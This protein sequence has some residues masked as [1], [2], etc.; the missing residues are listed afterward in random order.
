MIGKTLLTFALCVLAGTSSLAAGNS[1]LSHDGRQ[2]FVA[3]SSNAPHRTNLF[4]PGGGRVVIF[5]N[6]GKKYDNGRYWCC[7]GATITGPTALSGFPEFWQAAAFTPADDATISRIAVAVGFVQ[8]VNG[9]VLSINADSSGAPGAAIQSWDLSNLPTFGDCCVVD[10]QKNAGVP[11]TGGTQYW[12][13]VS[14][15]DSEKRTWA[16]W[17]LNDVEQVAP[18]LNATWCSADGGSGNCGTAN[19]IWQVYQDRPAFALAVFSDAP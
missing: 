6:I 2:T 7:T 12:I 10:L 5:S 13:V 16:A 8:G 3:P 19:D 1:V 4:D 18:S 11:V 14:T 9:L 15:N 17:N